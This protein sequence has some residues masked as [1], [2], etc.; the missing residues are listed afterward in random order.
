MPDMSKQP[1]GKQSQGNTHSLHR[2]AQIGRI[3][4]QQGAPR[5]SWTSDQLSDYD[6]GEVRKQWNLLV[7]RKVVSGRTYPFASPRAAAMMLDIA[8]QILDSY[9]PKGHKRSVVR[10]GTAV[11]PAVQA[12]PAAPAK[13]RVFTPPSPPDH[14]NFVVPP[15]FA[16]LIEDMDIEDRVRRNRSLEA[17][18][19]YDGSWNG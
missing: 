5:K 4:P 11:R 3:G 19:D 15:E 16:K 10:P 13:P 9:T 2:A 18:S 12:S 8:P 1:T 7:E 17:D 14:S 6:C